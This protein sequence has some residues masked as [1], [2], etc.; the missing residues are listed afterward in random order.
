MNCIP[1]SFTYVEILRNFLFSSSLPFLCFFDIS[2]LFTKVPRQE[3]M[4]IYANTFYDD[5]LVPPPFLRKMFIE[6]MQTT[7]SS[8]EISFNNTMYRQT[9]GV[10]MGLRLGPAFA[11]IFFGYQE[12]KLFLNLKKSLIYHR[13]VDDTF[14]VFENKDDNE[15]FL[16]SLNS[17]HSSLRFTFQKGLK[18]SFSFLTS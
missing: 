1:D 9:D 7:T 17:F 12:T 18:S 10:A 2:S 16:S 15:K 13:F 5:N 14:A 8:V 6:L 4:E 11:N 3:S